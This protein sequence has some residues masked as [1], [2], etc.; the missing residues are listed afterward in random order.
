[1]VGTKEPH[2]KGQGDVFVQ[3]LM[4]WEV[5]TDMEGGGGPGAKRN[6]LECRN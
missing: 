3:C 2:L 1:M 5:G 6:P 4:K